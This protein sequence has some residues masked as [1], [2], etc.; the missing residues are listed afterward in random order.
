M[1]TNN[2]SHLRETMVNTDLF[3][4][5]GMTAAAVEAFGLGYVVEEGTSQHQGEFR[6]VNREQDLGDK[7]LRKAKLSYH[8]VDYSRKYNVVIS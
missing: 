2:T 1:F 3:S 5:F 6:R 4:F 7:G 8:P